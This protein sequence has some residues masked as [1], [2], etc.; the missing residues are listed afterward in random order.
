MRNSLVKQI[1][2]KR[3]NS[4]VFNTMPNVLSWK[5]LDLEI[6][7]L[8]VQISFMAV[9]TAILFSGISGPLLSNHLLKS[10]VSCKI[11]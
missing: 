5:A 2:K 9:C 3:R 4:Q 10:R 7:L 8:L 11:T 1:V 6:S